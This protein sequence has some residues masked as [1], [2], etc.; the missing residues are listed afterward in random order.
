LDYQQP[1]NPDA[2]ASVVA[3]ALWDHDAAER[4][5]A[6]LTVRDFHDQ[7]LATVFSAVCGVLNNGGRVDMVT[8]TGQLRNDGA[9]D[10]VGGSAFVAE[11]VNSAYT[12]ANLDQ[13][14]KLIRDAAMAR[15][16]LA[17][18]H[19]IA[20]M[21]T[22]GGD[23][24]QAIDAAEA[25]VMG[26]RQQRGL[27]EIPAMGE[28]IPDVMAQ[29]EHRASG[30]PLEGVTTGIDTVDDMVPVI[31]PGHLIVLAARPSMGKSLLA[32]IIARHVATNYGPVA[33]FALEMTRDEVIERLIAS[34]SDTFAGKIT[35]GD[36]SHH[37]WPR[38]RQTAA[39][40]R[41]VP[42]YIDDDSRLSPQMLK[43]K[44]RRIP[45]LRMIVVDHL[46]LMDPGRRA[47]NRNQEVS[48]IS[49]SLKQIAKDLNVPVLALSQLN[50]EAA[51][52]SD[53]R[54]EM[55]DIRDSGSV[56]QD[57]DGIWFLH[58][59]N[60]Y[61]KDPA[62]AN[63]AE[64]IIAKQ[65]GGQIGTAEMHYQGSTCT[66]ASASFDRQTTARPRAVDP[67]DDIPA[68]DDPIPARHQAHS[69]F[70]TAEPLTERRPA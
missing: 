43:A 35:R 4:A 50:R 67:D 62:T 14:A 41:K 7:A 47:E 64:L 38:I 28:A 25:A 49:R 24:Q 16:L 19:R 22:K 8:V 44:C 23:V 31:R 26:I 34:E 66:F 3:V 15:D 33:F 61:T 1:S 27:K 60:Y 29:L 57:A 42:L 12:A 5:A 54:P 40:L 65:R 70:D 59:E 52:R 63:H 10:A 51:K 20:T 32:G 17:V 37:D 36:L 11:L 2:E 45:G 39:E 21:A 46:G 69:I 13:H 18:S 55:Q 6:L 58:R 30:A 48:I 53:K 56:E 9:L 68:F